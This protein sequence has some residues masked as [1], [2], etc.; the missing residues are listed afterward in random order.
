MNGTKVSIESPKSD[1]KNNEEIENRKN[2][3]TNNKDYISSQKK[4]IYY[5]AFKN[6]KDR[7]QYKEQRLNK[8]KSREKE[9]LSEF[10]LPL[11]N[12]HAKNFKKRD[13]F[14]KMKSDN[15]KDKLFM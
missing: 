6:I 14:Q 7:Y 9:I 11:I 15:F 1:Q 12:S 4:N 10:K 3:N 2:N 5:L 8:I 13:T